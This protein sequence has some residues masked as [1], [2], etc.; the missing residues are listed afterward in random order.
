VTEEVLGVLNG[1]DIPAEWNDIC[2]A[3]IT[4]VKNPE[5]MKDLRPISL[6]NVIYKLVSKVLAN[7]LK[8]ILEE[9]IAPNQSVFVPG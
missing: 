8:L 5:R 4:K 1:G 3:L 9:I 2:V 6:C 7:R